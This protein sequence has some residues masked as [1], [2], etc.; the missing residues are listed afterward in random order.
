MCSFGYFPGVRLWFSDVSEPAVSSI[1]KGCVVTVEGGSGR[2]YT[3]CHPI[4][5][6]SSSTCLW[7]WNR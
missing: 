1:F 5:S 7:R 3:R 4:P 2:E 6:H